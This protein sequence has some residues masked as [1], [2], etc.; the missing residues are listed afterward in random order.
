[1]KLTFLFS[2]IILTTNISLGQTLKIKDLRNIYNASK[3]NDHK[4]LISKGFQ[5]YAD[6]TS[7]YKRK[8]IFK[9]LNN[10][11]VIHLTN[12]D[13]DGGYFLNIQYY[14]TQESGYNSFIASLKND[15]FKYSKKDK[16]YSKNINSYAG[17][18]IYPIG[19]T[20]LDGKKYF[21]LEFVKSWGKELSEPQLLKNPINPV[22]DTTLK[23]Y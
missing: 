5:L 15:N 3:P 13:R 22:I 8:F 18:I 1:M 20:K 4:R 10:K 23:K 12:I 16:L 14:L 6:T 2:A 11:E 21:M 9:N 7:L 19:L 17:E